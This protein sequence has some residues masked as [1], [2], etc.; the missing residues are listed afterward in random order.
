M[1]AWR[2]GEPRR[3]EIRR[4]SRRAWS[5]TNK[6]NYFRHFMAT[7]KITNEQPESRGPHG[8]GALRPRPWATDM[9]RFGCRCS[10]APRFDFKDIKRSDRCLA[11]TASLRRVSVAN[12]WFERLERS[13]PLETESRLDPVIARRAARDKGGSCDRHLAIRRGTAD[14]LGGAAR[15]PNSRGVHTAFGGQCPGHRRSRGGKAEN[16]MTTAWGSG[17]PAPFQIVASDPKASRASWMVAWP[18]GSG[19]GRRPRRAGGLS[20]ADETKK[21]RAWLWVGREMSPAD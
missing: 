12:L 4:V 1:R 6:A 8:L 21:P 10:L 19:G 7:G 20:I 16:M 14:T 15:R 11:G 17:G 5:D 3:A 18:H 2:G 13:N 9:R